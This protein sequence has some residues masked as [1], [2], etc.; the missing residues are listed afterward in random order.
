[1]KKAPPQESADQPQA[2]TDDRES[3]EGCNLEETT[4]P[5]QLSLFCPQFPY[6][7]LTSTRPTPFTVLVAS[8]G[9]P[10]GVT[11]ILRTM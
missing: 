4:G 7:H 11:S 5:L 6:D 2:E 10:S 3:E 1:M 9:L 8:T